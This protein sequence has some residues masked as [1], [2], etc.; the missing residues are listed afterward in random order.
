MVHCR[1]NQVWK[2]AKLALLVYT[3][4]GSAKMGATISC[5]EQRRRRKIN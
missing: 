4:K 2:D 3:I 5:C 1:V